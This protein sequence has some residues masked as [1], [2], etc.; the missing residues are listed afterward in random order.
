MLSYGKTI[1]SA[2]HFGDVKIFFSLRVKIYVVNY[3]KIVNICITR[4][5]QQARGSGIFNGKDGD[6]REESAVA[7][8]GY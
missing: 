3:R 5:C 6:A 1:L 8:T 4:G 7:T 2:N